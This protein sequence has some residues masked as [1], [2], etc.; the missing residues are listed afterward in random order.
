MSRTITY[1]PVFGSIEAPV[2]AEATPEAWAE[3]QRGAL[4]GT[5]ASPPSTA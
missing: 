3:R 1:L 2:K 5:R 4:T